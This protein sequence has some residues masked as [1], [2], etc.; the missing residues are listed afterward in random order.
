MKRDF[1]RGLI[2]VWRQNYIWADIYA[3]NPSENILF[4]SNFIRF[5]LIGLEPH[6]ACKSMMQISCSTISQRCST[7]FWSG[8]CVE[9]FEIIVVTV[10]CS[11]NTSEIRKKTHC[12]CLLICFLYHIPQCNANLVTDRFLTQALCIDLV[13]VLHQDQIAFTPNTNW[14][15][16]CLQLSQNWCEEVVWGSPS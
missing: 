4:T 1:F 8:D 13:G 2:R 11:T 7:G 10:Y 12:M 5:T 9:V 14:S 15:R 3:G 6:F 16:V